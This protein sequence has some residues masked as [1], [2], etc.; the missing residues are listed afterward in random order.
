M[1]RIPTCL[2]FAP[3]VLGAP[4]AHGQERDFS[5]V[6]V[7][8][9]KLA[10]GVHLLVGAGG[11][12]GVSSGKDGV[13]LVDDQYAPLTPKIKAAVAAISDKPIRFILNTHWHGDHTGGNENLGGTGSLIVAHENVRRRMS[14][15]QFIAVFQSKIPASPE[16]ALP[17]VTY[18]ESVTFH[19]NGE[20]IRCFHVPPAHTDGDSIVHF[21]KADVVH[22]GD[23]Y[24]NGGYPFIDLDSGG[25]LAG[26]IGAADLVLGMAKDGTQIIPGHGPMAKKADLQAW[27]GM[28]V[29]LRDRVGAMVNAGKT[30]AEVQAAKPMADY[31][32]KLGK[33]FIK[34]DQVLSFAYASLGGTKK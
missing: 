30:L 34:P 11:N 22:M 15:D 4:L 5:K 12:I 23:L 6:E 7:T 1:R 20:E 13:F 9:T 10:E 19:L 27:R 32:E 29:A 33:G 25:S 18:S 21:T 14:V 2:A 28:L 26:Y 3:L 16:V 24:F 31:D 8:A 17:V